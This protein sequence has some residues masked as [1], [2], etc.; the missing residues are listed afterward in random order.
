MKQLLLAIFICFLISCCY[1]VGPFDVDNDRMCTP[2]GEKCVMVDFQC[3]A[4]Y[5]C[6]WLQ[7]KCQ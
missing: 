5:T 3:C 7:N 2:F 4:P 1:G 6:D